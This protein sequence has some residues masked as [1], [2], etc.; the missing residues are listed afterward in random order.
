MF[1]VKPEREP[2]W[3]TPAMVLGQM[4]RPDPRGEQRVDGQ[5]RYGDCPRLAHQVEERDPA[6]VVFAASPMLYLTVMMPSSLT[7][8]PCDLDGIASIVSGTRSQVPGSMS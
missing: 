3:M 1:Q 5:F 2:L 8:I 4:A 7:V 6:I